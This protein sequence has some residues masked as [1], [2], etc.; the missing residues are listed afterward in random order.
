MI[1]AEGRGLQIAMRAL[2][3]RTLGIAGS[4]GLARRRLEEGREIRAGA[5]GPSASPEPTHQA[6]PFKLDDM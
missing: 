2:G 5:H 4:R 1:G 6:I 3:R